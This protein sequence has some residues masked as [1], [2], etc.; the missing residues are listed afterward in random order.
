M[1]LLFDENISPRLPHLLAELFPG[2]QHVRDLGLTRAADLLIW[3]Y[4]GREGFVVVSKDSDFYDRAML[5]GAPPK[6][7]FLQIGN[8]GTGQVASLL[9][10][11][12]HLIAQFVQSQ[13]ADCLLLPLHS[14]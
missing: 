2:S 12:V 10:K 13:Q 11:N 4:A 6:V 5:A 1:K 14:R 7:V 3:D 9:R 8:A